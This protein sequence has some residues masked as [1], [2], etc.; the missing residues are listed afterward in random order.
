MM[1]TTPGLSCSARGEWPDVTPY[2]PET[3]GSVTESTPCSK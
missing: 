3:P 1:E 2:S